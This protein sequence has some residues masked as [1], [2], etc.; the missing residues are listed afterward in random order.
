MCRFRALTAVMAGHARAAMNRSPMNQQ[1]K[2]SSSAKYKVWRNFSI[3]CSF[4]QKKR[5]RNH[6]V[7]RL[8]LEHMSIFSSYWHCFLVRCLFSSAWFKKHQFCLMNSMM[9]RHTHRVFPQFPFI[10]GQGRPLTILKNIG[11][12]NGLEVL[13][14]LV[15]SFQPSDIVLQQSA[16]YGQNNCWT[17][18]KFPTKEKNHCQLWEGATKSFWFF[19]L[20]VWWV[21]SFIPCKFM[22]LKYFVSLFR[23][24]F[25]KILWEFFWFLLTAKI[26]LKWKNDTGLLQISF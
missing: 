17:R 23:N 11:D 21:F 14:N 15:Q 25:S 16:H 13:K 2:K 5:T 19:F 7:E 18:G 12:G 10:F 24:I 26:I 4:R 8:I 1:L 9:Q 22:R 20:F 6:S 3:I